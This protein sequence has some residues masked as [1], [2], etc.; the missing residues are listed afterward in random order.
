MS[1]AASQRLEA[2]LKAI[3]EANTQDPNLEHV[4]NQQIPKEL[5]YG[6]RMSRVLIEYAPNASEHLQIA[7]RAQHIERWRSPR[8]DFPEGRSG[9]KKWRS[10]LA[11]FHAQRAGE[12]MAEQGYGE[13]DIERVKFLVQ[14]RQLKRDNETQILEDVICL[15]FLQYYFE[16]F[17]AKHSEEKIIDIVQKTWRKMSDKGHQAALKIP[18]SEEIYKILQKSLA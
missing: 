16:P 7:A 8:S 10:Q 13:E 11:L 15:V 12:I 1:T 18:Y 14:K 17:A 9:Y 5:I 6:E 2:T 4:N 3:D